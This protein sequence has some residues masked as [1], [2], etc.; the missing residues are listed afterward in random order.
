MRLR[1]K[2]TARKASDALVEALKG[3]SE[4]QVA[5]R[6]LLATIGDRAFGLVLLL[7]AL[8]NCI[9]GPPGLG[10]IFGLPV[11]LF[12]FQMARGHRAPRLPEFLGR[13]TIRRE[14]LLSLAERGRPWLQMLERVC[15]PRLLSLSTPRGERVVGA[16]VTLLALAICVPLPLTNFIPAAGVLIMA[17]GLLEEDGVTIL[18]GLAVGLVGLGIVIAVLWMTAAVVRLTFG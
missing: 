11:V 9:P 18:L 5:I 2:K 4:E 15:R 14:T 3:F 16:L 13:R 7:F 10:S 1:S 8:P 6:D 12:G 17:L